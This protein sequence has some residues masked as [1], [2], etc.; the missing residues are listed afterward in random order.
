MLNMSQLESFISWWP[1]R[2]SAQG[3]FDL[4]ARQGRVLKAGTTI[5]LFGRN[6]YNSQ[7]MCNSYR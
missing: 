6:F 3:T 1:E 4:E 2:A 7:Q 5:T